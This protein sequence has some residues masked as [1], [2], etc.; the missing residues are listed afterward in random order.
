M[1]RNFFKSVGV[2]LLA[3][4]V[5]ALLSVVTDFLLEAI[6]ILPDPGKGLFETWAIVLVLSYRALYTI[7]AG[8]LIGRLAPAKPMRHA[9]LLGIIGTIITV[10]AA[11]SPSFAAKAPVWFGYA[12]AVTTIPCL[13]LGVKIRESWNK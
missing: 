5:N 4:V 8:Y 1:K 10:L 9:L 2:I 7:L 13:C 12:L 11:S 6:G 3:F